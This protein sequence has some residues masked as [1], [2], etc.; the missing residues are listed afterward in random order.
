MFTVLKNWYKNLLSD[1]NSATFFLIM[2]F[3]VLI[4][5]YLGD[6]LAPI[7]MALGVS[8][9]LEVPIKYLEKKNFVK[10]SFSTCVFM[11]LF[12][13]FLIFFAIS[14]IP[15]MVTQFNDLLKN[16]P[17]YVEKFSV[18]INQKSAEYPE[19]FQ[20]IDIVSISNQIG[21]KIAKFSSDFL[22][23]NLFGYLMNITS[24]ILYLII[25]PLMS[26]FMLKD[27]KALLSGLQCL[28]PSNLKLATDMWHKMNAQLMNYVSGK[29]MHICI[30][31]VVNF[32]AF[33]ILGLNYAV[34]LGFSVGISVVIPYVGSAIVTVPILI[35]AYIQFDFTSTFWLVIGVYL[36]IQ[37]LDG[38]VLVP[39]LFSEKMKL[40]PLIIL[41]SVLV[42][43]S[44][45]GFWGVFFAIPLATFIKTIFTNW[46]RGKYIDGDIEVMAVAIKDVTNSSSSGSNEDQ[47]DNSADG[48]NNS[49]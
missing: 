48:D 26:F 47:S 46:P 23:N 18:F 32:I 44:L 6:V 22:Q 45:W 24:F 33:Y 17:S 41:G 43:G 38:N 4:I 20:H 30:I 15:S 13:G 37:V 34:L 31:S 10:R 29:F 40:H 19:I 35:V 21:S 27:K 42:F 2:L 11:C 25:V 36:V 3:F 16:V 39:F 14:V 49:K 8:Y 5:Y 1:P 9:V 28:F 7:F 12:F